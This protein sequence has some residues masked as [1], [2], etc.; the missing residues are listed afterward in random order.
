MVNIEDTLRDAIGRL[1][2]AVV[3]FRADDGCLIEV[4]DEALRR[5]AAMERYESLPDGD[6]SR[7]ATLSDLLPHEQ[8]E[9]VLAAARGPRG[10]S[11]STPLEMSSAGTSGHADDV[12]RLQAL[13]QPGVFL[14]WARASIPTAERRDIPDSIE[15]RDPLTGLAD[16]AV[17]LEYLSARAPGC[18]GSEAALLFIDLDR[19]KLIND[20]HGHVA[21]DVL[22]NALA[23]RMVHALRPGDLLTRYGG[24]E[25]VAVAEGLQSAVDATRIA[26]RLLGVLRDPIEVAGVAVAVGASIGISSLPRG[27]W[28]A[29]E[30]IDLADRAMYRAKAEGG[31]CWQWATPPG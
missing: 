20:Q 17:L 23:Q 30:L 5:L 28:D 21:G 6:S 12:W 27:E 7:Q 26:D 11:E 19:F 3:V 18:D 8:A 1:P 29:A 31:N 13:D 10:S 16:R 24:D 15:T 25:F 9:R 22:L 2:V 14:L 4:S